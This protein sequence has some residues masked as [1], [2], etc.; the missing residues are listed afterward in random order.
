MRRLKFFIIIIISFSISYC[1]KDAD[2]KPQVITGVPIVT[3]EGV[4]FSANITTTGKQE[5]MKHGFVW[6]E[7][8]EP[9][10][11]DQ[12]VLLTS[13]P[14]KGIYSYKVNDFFL[15]E[16]L[17]SVRAYL[18]TQGYEI[19]GNTITFTGKG[20]LPPVIDSFSPKSGYAGDEIIIKGQ[21]F[22]E[23]SEQIVVKFG[24][25][26]ATI[27]SVNNST[28]YVKS[29]IIT[30]NTKVKISVI[31]T[32]MNCISNDYYEVLFSWTRKKDY[33]GHTARNGMSFTINEKGYIIGGINDL[34][35]IWEYNP[36]DNSW[37]M[38]ERLP[39]MAFNNIN[40]FVIKN[41]AYVYSYIDDKYLKYDPM[42]K[43]W[44]ADTHYPG[45]GTET[46]SFVIDDEVY[47]GTGTDYNNLYKE[48]Y[49][50][51]PKLKEWIKISD[52]PGDGRYNATGFSLNGKGYIGLGENFNGYYNDIWEYNPESN[53]WSRKNDF[54]GA[55]RTMAISFMLKSKIYVGLGAEEYNYQG[56]SDI[57][58]YRDSSDTWIK[59]DSYVGN[60]NWKNIV[61]TFEDKV[62]IG[63]GVKS[64]GGGSSWSV[65][66]DYEDLW[67]FNPNIN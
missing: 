26:I 52:F 51:N 29:P 24:E 40:L 60:G 30:E 64:K 65:W 21:N 38:K 22:P 35:Y 50:Y 19:Y 41:T 3:K 37:T 33:P 48:F 32:E 6:S 16:Q 4:E 15:K 13:K 11:K 42:S 8:G 66:T 44:S 2:I 27:D 47:I 12:S 61:F 1:E 14:K 55:K 54:P 46:A 31:V 17:F 57:W 20:S 28:L 58:E 53:I 34:Q 63:A 45:N 7:S 5:I 18:L 9:T 36:I 56:Y 62:Y 25:E 39:F 49:K 23:N 43:V 10:I 67:E 59:K